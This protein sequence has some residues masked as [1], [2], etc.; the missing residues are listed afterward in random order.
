MSMRRVLRSERGFGVFWLGFS[1]SVLGDAITRTTL[2]W[3]VFDLTGSSVSLGWL[4]FCF[5]A[6]VV[7]GGMTAGWLLDRCD[8]RTI[9]V[10]DSLAK[11]LVVVSVPVLAAMGVLPLWYVFVV[12][13]V[14]GFL[15]M[16]PLAGVPSLLPALVGGGDLNAANALET[17]GYTV[18]GVLGPP[19][20]GLLIARVGP[21][22]ALYLDAATYL[23]F[24]WAVGRCRPRPEE[25][26]A[27][28]GDATGL[29]AA[30]R[31]IWRSPVLAGTTLMYLVFNI[32]LGA[33]LVVV[34]VFAETVLG[35]GPELYG[36]LLGCVAVGE[37][38]SSVT[39]GSLRL[40]IPEGLAICLAALL[41]GIAVAAV[42]YSPNAA[43]A[44]IGL[45]LYGAFSAPLT[46]WGQTL[47]MKIIPP[48]FHGRCF[49]IMRTLMQSG[50]PLGGVSAGFAVPV[51]GVRAAIAGIALLTCLVGGLGL[52]VAELRRAR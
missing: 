38:A 43:G 7:V 26:R 42:A 5:T 8:R 12:A 29:L 36:L 47:R 10:L 20:A 28:T 48:G 44:V 27:E 23:V 13:G 41:S 6:P 39:I 9:M 31:V 30:A 52:T 4:S 49:A 37:L 17:V 40:S 19:L 22:E 32:G 16:I 51:L 33:L 25:A 11:S 35:G 1:A 2:I 34:P 3:Y 45:A 18:G 46:I 14:F 15:M 50:G 24:A 21:L